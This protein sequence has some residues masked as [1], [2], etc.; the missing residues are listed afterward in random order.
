MKK[1]YTA[2]MLVMAMCLTL[3][4]NVSATENGIDEAKNKIIDL[5]CTSII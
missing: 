1:K 4:I 3:C 5:A 2:F